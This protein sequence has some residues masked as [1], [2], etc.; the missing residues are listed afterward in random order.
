[1][2]KLRDARWPEEKAW[3]WYAEV[4]PIFGCNYLPRTAVNSTEMWQKET[5]DPKTIDQELGWARKAGYNSLRVFLQY[6]VWQDDPEGLKQ[7]MEQFLE[8]AAQHRIRVMFVPFCDCR[9]ERRDPYAGKQADPIPGVHNSRWVP[10]PGHQRV[11]DRS[12][13]PDLERYIKDVV[14][15]FAKD[16]RVLIW[17]LYNEPGMSG[18]GEKSLPLVVETFRWA[19]EV[20]PTQPL[21]IQGW[22]LDVIEA[23]GGKLTTDGPSRVMLDLSD[24]VGTHFYD[25]P[26]LLEREIEILSEYERPMFC[27]E[28]LRRQSNNRF[29]TI[30]PIFARHGV[31]CY[32]WG[33]VAGRTQTYLEGGRSKDPNPKVWR[34]DVFHPDGTP[35]DPGEFELLRQFLKDFKLRRVDAPYSTTK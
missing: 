8:I 30:L 25:K 31:S 24:V 16:R 12:A 22:P 20:N 9:F 23:P 13:W 35:Y 34:H 17:E 28:W 6:V 27:T 19:R 7:R 1:M 33:L 3:E 5:F 18:Q 11:N 14:G 32:H 10:S 4:A 21:M 15:H 2:Q 26:E 29:E